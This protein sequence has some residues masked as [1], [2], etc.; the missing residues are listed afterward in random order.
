[1]ITTSL[2]SSP[3]LVVHSRPTPK[4]RRKQKKKKTKIYGIT[5][6]TACIPKIGKQLSQ[7]VHIEFHI[8]IVFP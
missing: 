1:M 5:P 2:A 6:L 7:K 3:H 8:K 4:K